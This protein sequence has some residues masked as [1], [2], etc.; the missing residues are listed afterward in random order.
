MPRLDES[1]HGDDRLYG[2]AGNDL[3]LGLGGDD[4]LAGGTGSD[5]LVGGAGDD[6]YLFAAADGLDHVDDNDGTHT[7]LFTGVSAN[8]LQV[9]F[10]GS[11]VFVGT[12]YGAQGFYLDRS[13]WVNTRI[14]LETPDATIERS[15]L[16]TL[17]F[18]DAGNLLLTVNATSAMSEE[19]RDAL[20][21]VEASNPQRPMVVVRE[22]VDELEIEALAGGADGATMRVVSGGLQFILE[23]AAMQLATGLEFLN[24]ADGVPMNLTGFSDGV[25]GSGGAD[26]IIGSAGPD[27]LNGGGGNDLLEGRAGSDR[28][29]GG[30]GNDV[31][32]GEE[33]DDTLLG[34]ASFGSDYLDGGP[35]NDFLDGGLGPDTYAFSVGDGHD[36][37]SDPVGS[38]LLQFDAGVD[39]GSVIFYYT[40]T[41][42][43]RFR[44]EYGAGD[45]IESH[46]NFSSYWINGMTVGGYE[47]PLL[48]RS[49]IADGTFR[50]TRWDDVF[51]S[52]DGND[53]IHVS[54]WG[55]DA[56]R[57]ALGDGHDVILVE[58]NYYPEHMAEIRLGSDIDLES[59]AFR[60]DNGSAT[61]AYGPG[62]E[63]LFEP[64]KLYSPLDNTFGRFT[65]VSEADPGWLPVIRPEAP[66]SIVYGSFGADH[67][68]GMAGD[69]TILPGYGDDIVEAG[70]G[71]DTVVLND[72][73]MY[74]AKEGI[75][76][77]QIR[78]QAGDDVIRAPLHQGL[79]FHYDRGDG[80]DSIQYDWSFSWQDPYRFDLDWDAGTATF[81]PNG[82]DTL[83]FGAGITLA[84]LRFSRSADALTISLADG[85]GSVYIEDFF[86]AWDLDTRGGGRDLY[87][88]VSNEYPAPETL[89]DPVLLDVLPRSP[90]A[91]LR[92]ADGSSYDMESV[93]QT[94]L[95]MAGA[96]LLGTEGDD[97][98]SGTKFDDNLQALGGDDILVGGRGSDFM[99]GGAGDDI[100]LI[101]GRRQGKD[102]IIGGEGFDSIR[103]GE[104]DD[105]IRL[106]EFSPQ[107]GIE[108][109][110]GGPGS[111]TLAGSGAANILDFSETSLRDINVIEG[112]GGRDTITGSTGDDVI[113]GGRGKDMLS[114]GAGNDIY[115]FAPGDG[116]DVIANGDPDVSAR[117]SLRIDDLGYD[118]LWL[119]RKRD[120]LVVTV[121]GTRDRVLVRDWFNDEAS[122]LDAIYA[123]DHVLM[124]GQVDQLVNAMAAFD[125]PDGVG[126]VIS[127]QAR[128]ELEPVLASVWQLAG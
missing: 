25:Y 68:V 120:H 31:L 37:I 1:L 36:T 105:W 78:G 113:R 104:G 117:D 10:Q 5:S 76:H 27:S 57:F 126:D 11:Q 95:E 42:D 115:L 64:D 69:E 12:G 9:M 22:G 84:D 18:D 98:M 91:A 2:G 102:R 58:N 8:D 29:D 124:H 89:T 6:T 82:D 13:E 87:A 128:T 38:H 71:A 100:F 53:T 15:A 34:G 49:D 73:Y 61:I 45:S 30:S 86:H 67:I 28:L 56:I 111:N 83:A 97:H 114:G 109:I 41:S 125:V 47:I 75:G 40:G 66:G 44:L 26:R 43:S 70:D 99:D 122:Q 79:T 33:G 17:Y 62:D 4:L 19:D 92:F 121:A 24:L 116:R 65:L 60:F 106:L 52:R 88:L 93:L 54:G 112:R 81:L 21:T 85:S 59:L 103:G 77:K 94:H 46:G 118:Q 127:E 55:D 20:F 80:N 72:V 101:E 14:A 48:Q 108:L 3:L 16:D 96:V 32:R 63:A 35:G 23:L 110:D 7:L 50:D 119:S 90:I 107:D 123:G 39:P 74:Q 51:E